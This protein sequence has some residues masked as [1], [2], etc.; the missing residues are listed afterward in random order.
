MPLLKWILQP[1][2]LLL[3]IVVVALFVNRHALFPQKVVTSL[4]GTVLVGK[5][6]DT[7]ARLRNDAGALQSAVLQAEAS[8]KAEAAAAAQAMAAQTVAAQRLLEQAE[9]EQPSAQAQAT[10]ETM[11][12]QKVMTSDTSL[13]TKTPAQPDAPSVPVQQGERMAAGDTA[14]LWRAARTAVWQGDLQRSVELYR[15]LIALQEDHFDAYGEM[16]NVLLAQYDVAAAVAAYERAA[17]I[18]HRQGERMK[19]HQLVAII[20]QLDRERGRALYTQ[21]GQQP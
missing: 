6:E 9:P 10:A 17:Q 18:L 16:G 5:I 8:A 21:L 15:Q 7:V 11:E 20:T 14:S 12:G 4:E 3:L 13:A 19:A 1:V 2:Y